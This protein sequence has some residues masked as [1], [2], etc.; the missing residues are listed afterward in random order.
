MTQGKRF[1]AYYR[2]ST[3]E[4]GHSGLGIEAQR[5]AVAGYLKS[6]GGIE[7][8][9]DT[10]NSGKKVAG[11]LAEYTEVESG[12][13]ED[14]RP[15]LHLAMTQARLTGATLLIA[16][17]DRLSRDAHFLIGLE[18]AGVDFV[19]ADMPNA[20]RLTIRLMAVLAQE[21][22]E[23]ISART[24]AAL[25]A[26]KARGVKLGGNRNGR[27]PADA[28]AKGAAVRIAKADRFAADVGPI[29]IELRSAGATLAKIASTLTDRGIRTA[30]GGVWQPTTVLNV[31]NRLA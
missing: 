5:A 18:K 8:Q 19:A 20:N 26:A 14:N 13:R 1:V 24:K 15:Q 7:V 27:A 11:L 31:L 2:V 9:A 22:R 16:K 21:E 6:H 3:R 28:A 30:A 10:L 25:A 4:Q 29:I 12:K 17:I 23:M